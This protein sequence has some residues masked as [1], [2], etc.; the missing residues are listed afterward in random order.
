MANTDI[1][2]LLASIIEYA[3]TSPNTEFKQICSLAEYRF[4]KKKI[5][6]CRMLIKALD[7]TG[8]KLFDNYCK[9]IKTGT[10][11]FTAILIY[12]RIHQTIEFY[13][14]EI[15]TYLDMIE[16][17]NLFLKLN[18]SNFWFMLLGGVR[19]EEEE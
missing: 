15:D 3:A 13:K 10:A 7:K 12:Q 11:D 1:A 16:D 9:N 14:R 17:F 6:N 18:S 2:Q 5:K 8:K 19:P 4:Y